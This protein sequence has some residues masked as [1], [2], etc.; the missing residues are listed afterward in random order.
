MQWTSQNEPGQPAHYVATFD[1][2]S[3]TKEMDFLAGA[4]LATKRDD[5]KAGFIKGLKFI[6]AA[7]YPNGGW[8][9]IYPLET[10]YHDGVTYNDDVMV[11]I[12]SILRDVAKGEGEFAFVSADLQREA[13]ARAEHGIACILASQIRVDGKL[14]AWGQQHDAITLKPSAARA[15]EPA[16]P[17][18]SESASVVRLLMDLPKPSPA[19][20]AA[21]EGAVAWFRKTAI[22][23]YAET[24][25]IF[26][27]QPDLANPSS[28]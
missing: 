12:I 15:F 28:A 14:I 26:F 6:F 8:P 7:Q 17:C 25:T 23:G 27:I 18:S 10:G 24:A 9:Q 20:I 5:C 21:V 2:G 11:N 22:M 13:G 3:T 19:V 1:N 16:G 4:W